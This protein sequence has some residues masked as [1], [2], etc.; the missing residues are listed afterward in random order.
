MPF[1]ERHELVAPE[2]LELAFVEM[3]PVVDG[4]VGVFVELSRMSATSSGSCRKQAL[5][6]QRRSIHLSA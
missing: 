6:T 4:F 3:D 2:L 5:R 1:F